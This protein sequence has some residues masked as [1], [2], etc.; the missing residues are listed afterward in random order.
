MTSIFFD[1]GDF[2]RGMVG[3]VTPG[4]KIGVKIS[5]KL[6]KSLE[7]GPLLE[8]LTYLENDPI[9]FE[10]SLMMFFD[11]FDNDERDLYEIPEVREFY[12]EILNQFPNLLFFLN[13]KGIE[14]QPD[15]ELFFL[16]LLP[17]KEEKPRIG[18]S[19]YEVDASKTEELLETSLVTIHKLFEDHKIGSG[20][21]NRSVASMNESFNAM[22]K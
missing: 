7:T 11:G 19:Y 10:G 15:F 16:L 20:Y 21:Y 17:L 2:E 12:K 18:G 1:I 8:L 9:K 13:K 5:L 3:G 14:G 4:D 22:L 6:V